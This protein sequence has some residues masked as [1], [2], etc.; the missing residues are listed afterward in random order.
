M[1][2][3][4]VVLQV[5]PDMSY[6]GFVSDMLES[7]HSHIHVDSCETPNEAQSAI[8]V[9]DYDCLV[10][11]H[12]PTEFD[13][14][15]FFDSISAV[16]DAP[17]ILHPDK[18]TNG[19]TVVNEALQAGFESIVFKEPGSQVIDVL[20]DQIIMSNVSDSPTPS[21]YN[22]LFNLINDPMYMLDNNGVF[23]MVNDALCEMFGYSKDDLVGSDVEDYLPEKQYE[24]AGDLLTE[25]VD[26]PSKGYG[27]LDISI[28]SAQNHPLP[29]EISISP[30]FEDGYHIGTTGVVRD[31]TPRKDHY[32]RVSALHSTM[33]ELIDS[34]TIDEA[35]SKA[36]KAAEGLFDV[37]LAAF[38]APDSQEDVSVLVPAVETEGSRERI[39]DAPNMEP[40]SL[41]WEV[42]DEQESLYSPN[43]LAEDSIQN[44]N[45]IL[46]SEL[47]LPVGKFGVVGFASTE[48]DYLCEADLELAELLRSNLEEV[49]LSIQSQHQ[50]RQREQELQRENERLDEFAGIISHDLRNPLNV[51]KGRLDLAIS[52]IDDPPSHLE[53]VDGSI[54]RMGS[55]VDETLTL[56]RE[57]KTV[58]ETVE[59]SLGD[60][61]SDSARTVEFFDSQLSIESGDD[62]FYADRTKLYHV[63]E[64]L[65]RNALEHNEEKN[66]SEIKI[67]VGVLDDESGFFIEDNGC[68]IPEDR[69]EEVFDVGHTSNRR[70]TGLGL[71]ITSRIVEAHDWEIRATEGRRGGA[72]FEITGVEF[73]AD[74]VRAK[75]EVLWP[76]QA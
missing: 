44:N 26:D 76:P 68:G 39:G 53:Y 65:Y 15:Q 72:R 25:V 59:V 20:A 50:V 18:S 8:S 6:M 57:G 17:A 69:R 33:R 74:E 7:G 45:T 3:S 9:N 4:I 28:K 27:S 66:E 48:I 29:C 24:M 36:L 14:F 2:G 46:R 30:I 56:A 16:V 34:N 43:L 54:E 38:F 32:N 49:L 23:V 52:E 41:V 40:G 13:G 61:A 63:F 19:S 31:L 47:L 73:K 37:E 60:I 12:N 62:V 75:G 71:A 1:M 42:Y 70:G 55:I 11:S 58:G 35:V 67:T 5:G 22:S 64:N 21:N 10:I 51:A